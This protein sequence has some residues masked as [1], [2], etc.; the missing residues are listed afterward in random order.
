MHELDH[1]CV[2]IRQSRLGSA[3]HVVKRVRGI[4]KVMVSQ[5]DASEHV[6]D[7]WA[8][9]FEKARSVKAFS[10]HRQL[11]RLAEE[12]VEVVRVPV[13]P[14]DTLSERV[15]AATTPPMYPTHSYETPWRPPGKIYPV[16]P[17]LPRERSAVLTHHTS[18]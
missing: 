1:A 3:L 5:V 16:S 7:K 6:D 18:R 11:D 9:A 17:A 8:L 2:H 13:D 12:S 14:V 15:A 10:M 4:V